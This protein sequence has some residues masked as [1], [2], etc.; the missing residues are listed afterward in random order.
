M[1][2]ERIHNHLVRIDLNQPIKHTIQHANIKK[3]FMIHTSTR[4]SSDKFIQI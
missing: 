2:I 3:L 4:V 1:N